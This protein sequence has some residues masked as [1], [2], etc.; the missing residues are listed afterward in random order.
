MPLTDTFTMSW[1]GILSLQNV[2]F[3]S[4][5]HVLYLCPKKQDMSD[6]SY[7]PSTSVVTLPGAHASAAFLPKTSEVF[8]EEHNIAPIIINDKM[9]Y[10]SM[11]R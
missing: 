9:K 4:K 3:F 6:F 8:K 11:G 2:L 1:T 7:I 10:H 5:N